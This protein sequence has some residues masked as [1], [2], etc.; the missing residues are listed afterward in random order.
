MQETPQEYTVRL[1]GYQE[2]A[3]PIALLAATPK[4]LARLLKGFTKRT[5]QKRTTPDRWSVA[6]I[7]GH[8]AD[9]E[10]VFGYRLRF[11]LGASGTAVQAFDQNVWADFSQYGK[12]DPA[13]SLESFRVQREHNLRLLRLVPPEMFA[14]FG[15]HEER[16]KET[17][18]RL[19][20]MEA[21]HDVNHTRQIALLLRPGHAK[22][23]PAARKRK[24]RRAR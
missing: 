4:K 11:I 15:M 14:C 16:G 20:E 9:A 13:F 18:T 10:L 23:R 2:G 1:L 22:S 8:L 5:L 12:Q 7:L 3:D 24:K 19:L 21:G 17:V 6:E